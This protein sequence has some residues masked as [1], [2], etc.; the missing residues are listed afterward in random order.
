[1]KLPYALLLCLCAFLAGCN[2]RPAVPQSASGSQRVERTIIKYKGKD[3]RTVLDLLRTK[4]KIR[5]TKSPLGELVE[6]INGVANHGNDYLFFFVN[7]AMA[8]T[9][10]ANYVTKNGEV[11][12]WRLIS[13]KSQ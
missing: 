2:P 5:T 12:E 11:I 9:G 10:A 6:E 13:R 7:G 4:A 8:K 1:M 3:G